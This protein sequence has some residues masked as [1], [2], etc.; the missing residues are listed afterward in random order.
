MKA[1]TYARPGGPEVLQLVDIAEP[2]IKP[3]EL[4]VAVEAISVEG[5]DIISRNS[6]SLQPDECLGYAAAG[7]V[8]ATGSEVQDFVVGQKVATFNWRGAYAERRAVAAYNCFPIPEGLDPR[9]AAAIPV[10]P[11]TA[12][13]AYHLGKLQ[14]GQTVLILGA[15]GG[16]GV[17]AVQLAARMGARVIG[18]GTRAES[19]EALRQFGLNDAIVVGEKL[20]GEQVSE[21]LGGNH[22]DLL[23]DTIGGDALSDGVKVLRDGGTAVIIGILAGRNHMI[24]TEYLLLHRI[25]LIGCLLGVEWGEKQIARDL[26]NELLHMAAK[27]ELIVPID[28]TFPL[29]QA[30]E[31]HQRAETR[32][33]MGRVFITLAP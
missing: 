3:H 9:V 32:G 2:A 11:G 27:G 24:D 33:R 4:L 29:E 31:A 13:W 16:V 19:L 28:S 26:V 7:T 14:P 25:T 8:L 17:A 5:G 21:L 12:A 23:I 30:V 15:A 20:A 1:V 18:T 22:V 10:G 6:Q